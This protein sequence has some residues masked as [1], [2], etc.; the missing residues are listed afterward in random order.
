ME[1]FG[2]ILWI[3]L[4]GAS[5]VYNAAGKKARKKQSARTTAP[6]EQ[7]GEAWPAGPASDGG[8]RRAAPAPRQEKQQ[9]Q[10]RETL[11]TRMERIEELLTR[12]DR[13]QAAA[14]ALAANGP[15]QHAPQATAAAEKTLKNSRPKA[16]APG[17][18]A[19]E[20]TGEKTFSEEFDLKR[21]IIYSELL[22][23]KFDD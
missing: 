2:N 18:T 8:A 20:N 22:K 16:Q 10:P 7:H 21:A 12:L 13:P 6:Q 5:L 19:P 11:E 1:D 23:P 3:L 15:A 14:A 4:I 17:R 9:K